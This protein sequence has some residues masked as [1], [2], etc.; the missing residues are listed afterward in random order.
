MS[1]KES[2]KF[3]HQLNIKLN[4]KGVP[5]K[6][7]GYFQNLWIYLKATAGFLSDE[8]ITEAIGCSKEWGKSMLEYFVEYNV[9][10][11]EFDIDPNKKD[12][13]LRRKITFLINI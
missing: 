2:R 12:K 11:I 8:D 13:K 4:N 6:H 10:Q 1:T 5:V 3:L 7:Y 9:I